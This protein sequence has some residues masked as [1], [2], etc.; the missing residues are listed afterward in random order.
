M[1][2]SSSM[3]EEFK[4]V[5]LVGKYQSA[6]VAD[7]LAELIG[8]LE[9]RGIQ[10]WLEEQT[11]HAVGHTGN[12]RVASFEQIGDS[13][14]LV[15]VVGGDGTMLTTARRLAPYTLPLL[16]I[17]QGRLGFLTDVGRG[18]MLARLAEVLGGHYLRE[19]R[20][21]LEGEVWRD[22][23]KVFTSTAVND[24]VLSRGEFGRLIEFELSVDGEYIYT[25]R[26]D[27]MIIS[28]PTGSTA[29]SL[30]A[31]GPILHPR[32]AGILL[33]PLCPH[34]LTYRPLA[35]AQDSVIDLLMLPP[36]DSPVHFD[37]QSPFVVQ[38][39]DRLRVQRSTLSVT[40][41]HPQGYS[42]F[43][44]LREKLHWSAEPH[45]H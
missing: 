27:G 31:H 3:S 36:H 21:L 40:L 23:E 39:G 44:M 4:I 17:N 1:V 43:A 38:Q 6:E 7:A 30:S 2:K 41:L 22:R 28:T 25:Q 5:A 8:F 45:N 19:R 15:V 26:S 11:A 42:Y 9:P 33:V 14:D 34:A 18:E 24:I 10:V 32:L 16:G 37:A 20:S 35:L 13:A 29:Y 12:T